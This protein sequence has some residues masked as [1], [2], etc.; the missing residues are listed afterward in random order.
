VWSLDNQHI[1]QDSRR[2]PYLVA[3]LPRCEFSQQ[4]V[5]FCA[6]LLYHRAGSVRHCVEVD[7]S[8]YSACLLAVV[9]YFVDRPTVNGS[10]VL[11]SLGFLFG[12]TPVFMR[13]LFHV[14]ESWPSTF[15]SFTRNPF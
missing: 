3:A 1:L 12:E 5:E 6:V 2:L 8:D 4:L 15:K 7:A 11:K 9:I 13:Q 10:Q 14:D